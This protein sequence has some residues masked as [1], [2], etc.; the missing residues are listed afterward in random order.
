MNYLSGIENGAFYE[1]EQM[2]PTGPFKIDMKVELIQL[3]QGFLC[4][5]FRIYNLTKE[6]DLLITY[7][8]G[9]IMGTYTNPFLPALT[10]E[11]EDDILHWNKFPEWELNYISEPE[12]YDYEANNFLYIKIKERFLLPDP[13]IKNIPGASIEGLYYCRYSK[14]KDFFSGFY[15]YKNYTS[16]TSQ[17]LKLQR[18]KKRTAE[19]YEFC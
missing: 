3:R 15:F 1:G 4:G 7:F 9:E 11:A 6:H 14:Q 5:V 8:E 16:N 10:S 18:T 2:T 12:S 19:Y 17:H 13:S